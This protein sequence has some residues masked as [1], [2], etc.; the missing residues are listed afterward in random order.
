M[1]LVIDPN[2]YWTALLPPVHTYICYARLRHLVT[3][4]YFLSLRNSIGWKAYAMNLTFYILFLVLITFMTV[5]FGEGTEHKIEGLGLRLDI[6]RYV[7]VVISLFHV[8]KEIFQIWDEVS[9]NRTST[10]RVS[11][12]R[13]PEIKWTLFKIVNCEAPKLCYFKIQV[14][15][16]RER[17]FIALCS[18]TPYI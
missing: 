11:Q 4:W 7:I 17:V 3:S 13:K 6:A 14:L 1:Y 2:I 5:L 16:S 18:S 12:K 8:L 15:S 10:Y 9:G